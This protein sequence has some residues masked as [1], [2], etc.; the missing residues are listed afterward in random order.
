MTIS[1][2]QPRLLQVDKTTWVNPNNIL[3]YEAWEKNHFN[4]YEDG[5]DYI[6]LS[7]GAGGTESCAISPKYQE[8]F[9]T[10]LNVVV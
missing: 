4:H 2:M 10:A 8:N 5:P 6:T 1:A 3:K 7:D 9:R